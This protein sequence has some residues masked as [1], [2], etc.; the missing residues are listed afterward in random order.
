MVALV[1]LQLPPP[2]RRM[3]LWAMQEDKHHLELRSLLLAV[4][5]GL[6]FQNLLHIM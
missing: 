3:V 5:G 4:Q 6:T 1:E 2:L